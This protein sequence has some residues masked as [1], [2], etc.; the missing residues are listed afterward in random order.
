MCDF[1]KSFTSLVMEVV[2]VV[3][4]VLAALIDFSISLSCFDMS[5]SKGLLEPDHFLLG[6]PRRPKVPR[7]L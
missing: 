4:A 1:D 3:Q 5:F 6:V 7:R 2:F